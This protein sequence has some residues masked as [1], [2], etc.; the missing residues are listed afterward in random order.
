MNLDESRQ[1]KNG[2]IMKYITDINY[3][4]TLQFFQKR[5]EKYNKENPYVVTMYQ[6]NN[7]QMVRKRNQREVEVLLPF[8]SLDPESRVLDV[9]CGIGRWNDALDKEIETYCG[10]DFCE[11]LIKIAKARHRDGK[12]VSFLVGSAT[13]L[14]HILDVNR[15]GKFNRILMVGVLMYLND[16]DLRNVLNQVSHVAE[17][18]AILCIREPIA[19][20]DR[21]TLKHFF[22][23][24]LK[25]NYNAIYRTR[26]ELMNIFNDTLL[27]AGFHVEN[28]G[29]LFGDSLN[30]R[31]ETAQ[32]YFV[33]RRNAEAGEAGG[34]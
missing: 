19:I 7:P 31:K 26:E 32:Y 23:E 9:A 15:K 29:W 25:D 14:E 8:L 30:N 6:D 13:D 2:R 11:D 12:N 1:E 34:C 3:T 5:A 20:K 17:K 24:E 21:L 22:S 16:A 28:E 10:L 33:F 27:S 18:D 4:E